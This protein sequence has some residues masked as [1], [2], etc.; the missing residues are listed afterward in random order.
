MDVAAKLFFY[1]AAATLIFAAL[2]GS[3]LAP[4]YLSFYCEW[5][6]RLAVLWLLATV[7]AKITESSSPNLKAKSGRSAER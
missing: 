7:A 3:L 5:G 6:W 4:G 1:A 2:F